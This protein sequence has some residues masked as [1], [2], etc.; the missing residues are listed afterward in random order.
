MTCEK[1]NMAIGRQ[2][3][4]RRRELG[5]S[6]SGVSAGCGVSLQQVH[7][8]ETGRSAVSAAMLIPLSCCLDVPVGYFFRSLDAAP[9]PT[10]P[11]PSR[12]IDAAA[13]P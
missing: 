3:A 2:I 5:M 1:I 10:L 4:L 6:L 13:A 12:A 7:K 8:Y 9:R 11:Q